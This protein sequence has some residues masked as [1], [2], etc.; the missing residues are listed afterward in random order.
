MD[1]ADSII[2]TKF[3][4]FSEFTNFYINAY[5]INTLKLKK[6]VA[7]QKNKG[8]EITFEY[9]LLFHDVIV[10]DSNYIVIAE[11]YYPEYHTQFYTTY[12]YYGRPI[13]ITYQ[14]FD[15]YRYTSALI[16]CFNDKGDLQ[17]EYS[18]KIWDILSYNLSE[19]VKVLFDE[20]DIVLAYANEGNIT[21]IV[22]R[23][24]QIISGRENYP[25]ETNYPND[26][27]ITD[28]NSSL[29]YWYDNYFISYGY[30]KIK[31]FREDVPNK[32]QVFYF[33]KIAFR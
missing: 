14:I 7:R 29:E 6:K 15:G 22:I 8:K 31:N 30:Q 26:K 9:D 12:D 33:N 20:Q 24:N 11:A 1:S 2:F 28:F 18:L 25:I 27:L 3:Y 4:N 5:S 21:S 10:R 32:R 23:G 13:T 16:A 19:R 17:W